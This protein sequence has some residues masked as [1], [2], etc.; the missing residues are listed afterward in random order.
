MSRTVFHDDMRGEAGFS[1]IE[2]LVGVFLLSVVSVMTTMILSG[3][4]RGGEILDHTLQRLQQVDAARRTMA[5]DLQHLE[6]QAAARFSTTRVA[7]TERPVL[8]FT[9]RA[10]MVA[11]LEEDRSPLQRIEYWLKGNLL[12]RRHYHHPNP[13]AKTPYRD[14][15]LLRGV[16]DLQLAYLTGGGWREEAFPPSGST[17]Q[18]K[19]GTG[20][21]A[22]RISWRFTT[23]G[24]GDRRYSS[25]FRLGGGL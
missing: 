6:D 8:R 15:V 2:M 13:T 25:L 23:D 5:D 7:G 12:V 17:S 21:L 20:P 11:D 9:R 14:H 16:R 19:A 22:V 1:L 3:Y 18:P 10:A 4:F 24:A